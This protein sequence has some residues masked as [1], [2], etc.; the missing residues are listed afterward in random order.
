MIAGKAAIVVHAEQ[1]LYDR[2]ASKATADPILEGMV[3]SVLDPFGEYTRPEDLDGSNRILSILAPLD[4]IP[5]GLPRVMSPPPQLSHPPMQSTPSASRERTESTDT[6]DSA[7]NTSPETPKHFRGDSYAS[8]TTLPANES[9]S[10]ARN[11][12]VDGVWDH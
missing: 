3:Q 8:D 1:A 9:P 2:V 4:L 10:K 12:K 11:S 6:N 5:Q 7:Y